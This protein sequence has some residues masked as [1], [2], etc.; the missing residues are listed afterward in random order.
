VVERGISREV[1]FAW[2]A[3]FMTSSV[4][5]YDCDG[6]PYVGTPEEACFRISRII[7]IVVRLKA[8]VT[9]VYAKIVGVFRQNAVR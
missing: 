5:G 4:A 9:T 2:R 3:D 7:D 6:F 8:V 1:N